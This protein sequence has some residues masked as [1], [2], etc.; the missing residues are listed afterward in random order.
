[1]VGVLLHVHTCGNTLFHPRSTARMVFR[2]VAIRFM[3]SLVFHTTVDRCDESVIGMIGV[4]DTIGIVAS[5][6]VFQ[7]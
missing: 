6:V 4:T 1:M 5:V 2:L 7:W 3:V